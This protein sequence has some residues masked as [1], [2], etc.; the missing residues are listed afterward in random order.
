MHGVTQMHVVAH[1]WHLGGRLDGY[2]VTVS[3][4]RSELSSAVALDRHIHDIIFDMSLDWHSVHLRTAHAPIVRIESL[5]SRRWR[6]SM[7][8]LSAPIRDQG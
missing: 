1:V 5:D 6:R 3:V 8:K 7:T 2:S 4:T